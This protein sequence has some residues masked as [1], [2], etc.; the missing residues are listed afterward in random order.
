MIIKKVVAQGFKTYAKRTE[1]IFDPGVTA[2]VG[3]NGSGKSNVADA[4]RWCLGEQSFSLLRS[5]K[6]SDVIFSGSDRKSRLG[7][8]Q[9]S[10]TLDNSN[11]ELPVDFSE[12]EITRRA[13]RDGN[14]EYL[15][16]GQRVRLTDIT[17]I[18]AATGLGKRT[19][20]LIGQGLIE[21]VI[22]MAPEDLRSLFEEAAGITTHQTKRSAAMRRLDAA[23]Q[24]LTR[25]K[26]I[27][28]EISPRLGY[29]RRQAERAEQRNQL[30]EQLRDLL[31]DWYGYHWHQAKRQLK[32]AGDEAQLLGKRV[33]KLRSELE[34]LSQ[35]IENKRKD[36]AQ[37]RSELSDLHRESSQRHRDAEQNGRE[38]A[39]AQ[40]R[41]RQVMERIEANRQELVPLRLQQQTLRE[42]IAQAEVTLTELRKKLAA[43]KE[44]V[45][46]LQTT[47]N[48]R[49]QSQRH[50]EEEV[51]RQRE[52]TATL[53][54]AISHAQSRAEQ[55]DTRYH[56]LQ[57]ELQTELTARQVSADQAIE[58]HNK[59]ESCNIRLKD[60]EAKTSLEQS[61]IDSAETEI[62][63]L[64][65]R[66][67]EATIRRQHADRELDR[68]QTRFDVLNR[69]RREGAGYASGVQAIIMA[70]H[71]KQL[72]GIIGTVAS[73]LKVPAHLDTAIETA[74]GGSYQ[75]IVTTTWEAAQEAIEYLNSSG[76]GRATFLPLNRLHV[77]PPIPAP[78]LPGVIGNACDLVAFPNEGADAIQQLLNRVWVAEDLHNARAALDTISHG[79]RPTVVTLRGEIVRPGGAVSGGKDARHSSDSVHSR[80]RELR[81]LPEMINEAAQL[82]MSH[83]EN[84]RNLVS[85]IQVVQNRIPSIQDKLH[86]ISKDARIA[87]E[88]ATATDKSL[89][90]A[91]QSRDWHTARI[92]QIE[93]DLL[94]LEEQQETISADI[95]NGQ[96]QVEAAEQSLREAIRS[97]EASGVSTVLRQLADLRAAAA[98]TQGD[99]QSQSAILDNQKRNLQSTESQ[100]ATR[101]QQLLSQGKEADT[102]SESIAQL[103][104]LESELGTAIAKLQAKIGPIEQR[105][106][107]MEV[108]QSQSE[109]AERLLQ[110]TLRKDEIE[111]NATLLAAQRAQDT[112]DQLR[113]DIELEFGLVFLD[114]T[115]EE[116]IQPPLPLR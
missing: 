11:N 116:S 55:L 78:H 108:N 98:E 9:V 29:L 27:T 81:E 50:L 73:L 97:A 48:Q 79:P 93:H 57:A 106:A 49:Q 30:A 18:L 61:K 76:N 35:L 54:S 71:K 39:V 31:E 99:V 91:A 115:D 60:A 44:N 82:A 62:D 75:N 100:I 52:N 77:L 70:A 8:A 40:E 90:R 92:N 37:L 6:T 16:N 45:D 58:L 14:N 89:E 66:L 94:A 64:R 103:G 114:E 63:N 33:T 25:V 43:R 107:Q 21:R 3:P 26:D 10:V 110:D 101:E 74:L 19:Y 104:T 32:T 47:I 69:L 22:S 84:C 59:V 7:M 36:Q 67:E 96:V 88:E 2:I 17:E 86:S 85:D 5:K 42:R 38:L 23:D 95:L 34:N 83:A 109:A 102:L 20:A 68:L 112:I 56:E 80:E 111:W 4:I 13:Y 113:R 72:H 12:V 65:A 24:N 46:A 51:T 105:L 1:F 15:L 87:R 53:R 28:T 41:F